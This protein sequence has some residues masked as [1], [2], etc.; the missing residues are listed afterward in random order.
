MKDIYIGEE[1][2]NICPEEEGCKVVFDSGTSVI[3]GPTNELAVLLSRVKIQNCQ[4]SFN[5]MPD[6]NFNF[7]GTNFPIKREDY[8][9]QNGSNTDC[10]DGFMELDLPPPKGPLWVLG[11]IF[12]RK[13]FVVFDRDKKRIGIAVRKLN[14]DVNKIISQDNSFNFFK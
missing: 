6:I 10:K 9:F 2:T 14:K 5:S 13:Y 3:T 1:R 8:I 4:T 12:M 7:D 11:D